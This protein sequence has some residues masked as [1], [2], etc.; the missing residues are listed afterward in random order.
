M[1]FISSI[2]GPSHNLILPQKHFPFSIFTFQFIC[3]FAASKIA[4]MCIFAVLKNRGKV[5]KVRL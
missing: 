3:I 5:Y 1:P 4:D 2:T